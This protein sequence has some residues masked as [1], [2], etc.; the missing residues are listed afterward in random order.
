M[1]CTC[2]NRSYTTTFA[3]Y[4]ACSNAGGVFLS[5][6]GYFTCGMGEVQ[7]YFSPISGPYQSTCSSCT[8]WQTK[9]GTFLQCQ[10]CYY[11]SGGS[12][13]ATSFLAEPQNCSGE[14]TNVDGILT[15]SAW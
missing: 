15:C 10:Q 12:N 1:T 11:Q 13:F 6:F 2:D 9:K 8:Q 14:I 3:G 5:T 4:S 7:K